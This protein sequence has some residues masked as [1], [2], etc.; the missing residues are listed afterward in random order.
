MPFV[1]DKAARSKRQRH[2]SMATELLV[3]EIDD[4]TLP[5]LGIVHV[6]VVKGDFNALPQKVQEFIAQHV[7]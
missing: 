4:V 7:S 1:G 2:D 5:G 6:P 3:E